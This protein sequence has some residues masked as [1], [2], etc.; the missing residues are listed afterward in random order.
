MN[1]DGNILQLLL[2]IFYPLYFVLYKLVNLIRRPKGVTKNTAH[3]YLI[4]QK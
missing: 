3:Y 4:T 1:A 2:P